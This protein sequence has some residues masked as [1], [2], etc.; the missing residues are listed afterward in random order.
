MR[1]PAPKIKKNF[2]IFRRHRHHIQPNL[3]REPNADF[4]AKIS[5]CYQ[6]HTSYPEKSPKNVTFLLL[7]QRR[8]QFIVLVIQIW[9]EIK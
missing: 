9:L 4:P 5:I 7:T 6:T 8:I 3:R 2:R 1:A